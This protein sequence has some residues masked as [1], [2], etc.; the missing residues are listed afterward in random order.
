MYIELSNLLRLFTCI[1]PAT[2]LKSR[3]PSPQKSWHSLYIWGTVLWI[4]GCLAWPLAS[5]HYSSV[6]PLWLWQSKMSPDVWRQSCP[7]WESLLAGI[8]PH[9]HMSFSPVSLLAFTWQAPTHPFHCWLRHHLLLEAF[10]GLTDTVVPA[11]LIFCSL[12]VHL[13][14]APGTLYDNSLVFHRLWVP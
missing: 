8:T 10:P 9:F 1:I 12:P 7:R 11:S 4:V 13:D 3:V 14:H 5:D 6:A 2:T